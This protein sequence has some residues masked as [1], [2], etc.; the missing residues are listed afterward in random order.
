MG[1]EWTAADQARFDAAIERIMA[2]R[3]SEPANEVICGHCGEPIVLLFADAVPC[4]G[5]GIR[6]CD[7]CARTRQLIAAQFCQKGRTAYVTK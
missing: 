6:I 2:A 7:S 5:C 1:R 3:S 4:P